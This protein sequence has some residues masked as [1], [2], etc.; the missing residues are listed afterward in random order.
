M[1]IWLFSYLVYRDDD[2]VLQWI[3]DQDTMITDEFNMPW[4]YILLDTALAN[5]VG[6]IAWTVG[7]SSL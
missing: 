5:P 1:D 7:H 4:R 6:V 2:I 3:V